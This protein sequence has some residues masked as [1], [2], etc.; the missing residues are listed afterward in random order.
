MIPSTFAEEEAG[1]GTGAGPAM[2]PARRRMTRGER[3][4]DERYWRD[5]A[6]VNPVWLSAYSRHVGFG[7]GP[8]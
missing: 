8:G 2:Q 7:A 4:T 3:R 5:D 1:A 6:R